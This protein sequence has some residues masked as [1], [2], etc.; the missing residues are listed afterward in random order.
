MITG[1]DRIRPT[2]EDVAAVLAK[3]A[4]PVSV[5]EIAWKIAELQDVRPRDRET[6]ARVFARVD[7]GT[8]G[9]VLTLALMAQAGQASGRLGQEWME[10]LGR[11]W[12]NQGHK[13]RYWADAETEARWRSE[14]Q[15][16]QDW[17]RVEK[18][19]KWAL[20]QLRERY[21]S[22]VAALVEQW[23]QEHPKP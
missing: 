15:A 18:A 13:T 1:E 19:E 23:L 10:I 22:E 20:L 11:R 8:N 2:V 17:V 16:H 4:H 12:K 14:R 9:L 21:P 3:A 5:P 6:L 7:Q